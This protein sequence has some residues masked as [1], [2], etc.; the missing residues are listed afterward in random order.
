MR[1]DGVTE[2]E[3]SPC[4]LRSYLG[5]RESRVVLCVV[6]HFLEQRGEGISPGE[7][8]SNK[9]QYF[10]HVKCTCLSLFRLL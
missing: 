7:Q 3:W 8:V 2:E 6:S 5:I 9:I 4:L 1:K 10:V